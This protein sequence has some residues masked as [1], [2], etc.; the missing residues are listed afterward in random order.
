MARHPGR[1]EAESR[2]P[3]AARRDAAI[4]G[5]ASLFAAPSPLGPG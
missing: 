5:S 4:V 2:D 1:S 3:G